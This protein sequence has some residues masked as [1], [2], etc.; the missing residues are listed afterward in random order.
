MIKEEIKEKLFMHYANMDTETIYQQIEKI[1]KKKANTNADEFINEIEILHGLIE[2][3]CPDYKLD[4]SGDV[5][6]VLHRHGFIGPLHFD[7]FYNMISCNSN[8][9]IHFALKKLWYRHSYI[10]NTLNTY[11]LNRRKIYDKEINEIIYW[12]CYDHNKDVFDKTRNNNLLNIMKQSMVF[13]HVYLK[14]GIDVDEYNWL[15]ADSLRFS[16][17]GVDKEITIISE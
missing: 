2:K 6:M 15:N 3:D 8:Y 14:Y 12:Y 9:E 16:T 11:F 10:Y 4:Y 1:N 5:S 17:R 7:K 13:N